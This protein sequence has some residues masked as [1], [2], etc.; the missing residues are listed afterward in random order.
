M[1]A[2]NQFNEAE[3]LNPSDNPH[4]QDLFSIRLSRRQTLKG[5]WV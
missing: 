2:K 1:H 5:G 3:N 4:I